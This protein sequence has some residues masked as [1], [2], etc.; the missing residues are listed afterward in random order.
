MDFVV[1]ICLRVFVDVVILH[2]LAV[3]CGPGFYESVPEMSI[4]IGREAD[5]CFMIC[6]REVKQHR[7]TPGRVLKTV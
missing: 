6:V 1:A 2:L 5:T 3:M 4:P 7:P